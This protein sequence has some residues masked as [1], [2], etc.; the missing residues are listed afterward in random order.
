MARN[1]RPADHSCQESRGPKTQGREQ[2]FEFHKLQTCAYDFP[3]TPEGFLD[4][5]LRNVPAVSWAPSPVQGLRLPRRVAKL[6]AYPP[7]VAISANFIYKM[8][9][10]PTKTERDV[11]RTFML[12]SRIFVK[13]DSIS[14]IRRSGWQ[15]T[16]AARNSLT[17]SAINAI[18]VHPDPV[19]GFD[20]L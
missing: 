15:R 7:L 11:T 12:L 13:C 2:L 3:P 5:L 19:V 17:L 1:G 9:C 20:N 16:N 4:L 14:T 18:C 6:H 10:A 8:L